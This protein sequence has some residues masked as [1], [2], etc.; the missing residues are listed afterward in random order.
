MSL[1]TFM[2]EKYCICVF[3]KKKYCEF[4]VSY[5]YFKDLFWFSNSTW[6]DHNNLFVMCE[7]IVLFALMYN[8]W[9]SDGQ[10][11]I[12]DF[13]EKFMKLLDGYRDIEI[14]SIIWWKTGEINRIMSN[15]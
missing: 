14:Y 11:H 4:H 13:Q 10:L 7:A 6:K 8:K 12:W 1:K 15:W 2:L 9:V 3:T 5:L